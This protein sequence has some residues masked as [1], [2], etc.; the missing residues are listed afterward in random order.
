MCSCPDR[1]TILH[2][3]LDSFYASVEQRDDPS[4]RGRP[5]AV[6]GGVVL[7]ASYEAKRFGVRTAMSE[8]RRASAVP[9]PD[10]RPAAV[11]GV[12]AGEQGGLRDL[13][14]H[15]TARRGDLDRRSVPRRR[16][17]PQAVG[18]AGRDRGATC[19]PCARRGRAADH[20]RRGAHEVPRQGRERRRQA[21]R[22]AR[23]RS[24]PR[25][26]V[27]PPAAGRE[28]VGR[29]PGH[30]GSSTPAV[31]TRSARSP[32]WTRRRSPRSSGA[33]RAANCRRCRTTSTPAESRP[34]SV[35]A[36]SGR[37]RRSGRQRGT[38]RD[39][40]DPARIVDRV[41]RRM[42]RADRAGRTVT[43]RFRFD[44]FTRATRSPSLPQPTSATAPLL[45][46]ATAVL[47]ASWPLID[48][49]GGLTLIGLSV[50]NLVDERDGGGCRWCCR[51][52]DRSPRCSTPHST[53]F[54]TDSAPQ[55]HPGGHGRE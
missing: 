31:S 28:A 3:D 13:R 11:R 40:G 38:R 20:G 33:P 44:D 41:T 35:A 42:R 45:A 32:R 39:R 12:L 5:V 1:A 26:R 51:S 4:L 49:R 7:A 48:E 18:Y 53:P 10:R 19:A 16:R 27:P 37:S 47:D 43:L 17:A 34:A 46:T 8:S 14:R 54:V 30:R 22:A 50:G 23:R 15:H 6:G 55:P 2:A 52:S 29:R 21:R 25:A 9:R 24:G 36:R